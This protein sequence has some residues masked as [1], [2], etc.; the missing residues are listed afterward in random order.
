MMIGYLTP[1]PH[2][3][4]PSDAQ[5]FSVYTW[6]SLSRQVSRPIVAVPAARPPNSHGRQYW[7]SPGI[8]WNQ[9]DPPPRRIQ[10]PIRSAPGEA[11]VKA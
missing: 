8:S 3:G 6:A 11:R 7:F 1:P 2:R 4:E 10:V 9:L 5:F